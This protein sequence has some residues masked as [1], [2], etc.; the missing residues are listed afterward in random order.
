M[1]RM[2]RSNGIFQLIFPHALIQS[3]ELAQNVHLGYSCLF[4]H[5]GKFDLQLAFARKVKVWM[6]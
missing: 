6:L 1:K 3:L 4:V 5:S 2:L